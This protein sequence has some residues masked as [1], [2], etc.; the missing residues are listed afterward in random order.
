MG[1][2]DGRDEVGE[3]VASLK[4]AET[5]P[6]RSFFFGSRPLT[7]AMVSK[8]VAWCSSPAE[9]LVEEHLRTGNR[10][11]GQQQS[12]PVVCRVGQAQ[13]RVTQ[14]RDGPLASPTSA[15]SPARR[16]RSI[17]QAATAGK[18]WRHF[19]SGAPVQA[20]G[21]GC[22]SIRFGRAGKRFVAAG[23]PACRQTVFQRECSCRQTVSPRDRPC[24]RP[25]AIPT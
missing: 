17:L 18:A 20:N 1:A 2:E 25:L 16:Y 19:F 13:A 7:N 6:M 3:R 10:I 22:A 5:Y 8:L 9:V 14:N 23:L 12:V 11:V 4:S 15:S 21:F 24:T